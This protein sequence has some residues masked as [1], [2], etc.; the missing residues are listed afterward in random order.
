MSLIIAKIVAAL[1]DPLAP[2]TFYAV[3]VGVGFDLYFTDAL[4][5]TAHALNAASGGGG[6]ATLNE[7]LARAFLR[8]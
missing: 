1:P 7:V 3:R 4:G 8:C 2:D 6:G 5:Q